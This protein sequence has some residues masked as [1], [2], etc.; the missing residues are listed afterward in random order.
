LIKSSLP[1]HEILYSD[2]LQTGE[3]RLENC[4]GNRDL[5]KNGSLGPKDL[6]YIK[7]VDGKLDEKYLEQLG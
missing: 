4:L 7:A 2:G 3:E 5:E 6:L 1:L